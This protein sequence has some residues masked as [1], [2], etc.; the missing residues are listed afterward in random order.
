MT[1]TATT[2]LYEKLGGRKAIR[3]VVSEFY[4][5]VLADPEL[6]GYFAGVDMDAQT[7]SQIRF[8]SMALGGPNEYE[9]RPMKEAHEDLGVTDHHFN[10]VAGHLVDTLKW[11][12]VGEEEIS[13]VVE[14]VAPL[15]SQIVTV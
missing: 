7:E 11:A 5:R 1:M 10:L 4:E 2:T 8:I 12:G 3:T 14:I 6:L 13:A 15:K 9:G